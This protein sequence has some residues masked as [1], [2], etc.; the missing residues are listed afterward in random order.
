M[1]T[2]TKCQCFCR[3]IQL[4]QSA[5]YLFTFLLHRQLN[6][7]ARNI[8]YTIYDSNRSSTASLRGHRF[9]GWEGWG[10]GLC[11]I[12]YIAVMDI[13]VW[14][15]SWSFLCMI[16]TAESESNPWFPKRQQN[17]NSNLHEGTY[18]VDSYSKS[19]TE[20][21]QLLKVKHDNVHKK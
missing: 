5:I 2:D 1:S 12:C 10:R 7:I 3:L 6:E 18:A 20:T 16:S 13:P 11:H 19:G 21:R 8:W 14:Y 9:G 4:V 15:P 17:Y